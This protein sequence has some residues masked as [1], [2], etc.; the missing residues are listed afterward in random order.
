MVY[1]ESRQIRGQTY[2]YLVEKQRDGPRL[3]KTLNYYLGTPASL[4]ERL[5]SKEPLP[6]G[7]LRLRSFP[8]GRAALLLRVAQDLDLLTLVDRNARKRP[9]PG[10]SVGQ[11]LLLTLLARAYEPWSKA[12]TGRWFDRESFLRFLW[13]TPHRVHGGSILANL[14][15]LAEPGVQKRVERA[16]AQRLVAQGHRPSRLFWDVTNH[17]TY[18][19]E[20][21]TLPTPGHA[22]DLRYDLNLV[23]TGL[24][25]TE[26]HVPLFHETLPGNCDEHEVFAKAV[27]ALTVR[28]VG[29][30][31]DPGEMILVMDK[32]ANSEE[33]FAKATELMHVVGSVPSHLVPELMD[34]PVEEFTPL[35]ETGR[36][37]PLV[38]YLGRRELYGREWNVAVTYNAA[39]ARR[40]EA[41]YRRYEARFRER[42][43]KLQAGYL[44]T[45]G[46]A[47]TYS[48]A[49][50][51]AAAQVF[52]PYRSVFR[53]AISEEPRQFTWEVDEPARARLFRRF[54]KRVF[55]TDLDWDAAA[56]ART[57]EERYKVEQD[58]AWIKGEE[59]MPFAPLF[60]R[61]D[62]SIRA[63]AFLIVMGLMLWRLAFQ[64]I[65]QAGIGASEGEI[66]EALD[67]LKVALVAEGK[68]GKLRA[69]RWVLEEHGPL[70]ER[71]FRTMKLEEFVP[72]SRP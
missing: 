32:G 1:L 28:L 30:E 36:G 53:Y 6:S 45:K 2:W 22:K 34:H 26:D 63:H 19:E 71:L 20:G 56:M 41:T 8:F 9:Y 55:F 18:I 69:G 21:E 3:V 70:A 35:H 66:L 72:T 16:V 42:M 46:R 68:G 29:L 12:A 14:R 37:T 47:T 23:S 31:L 57:Y 4:L 52:P 48:G 17:S 43:A 59:M 33:N 7:H 62:A 60:V 64:R 5:R 54:G 15:R 25:V 51:E 10:L 40:K 13:K 65:R 49:A 67:E 61:K 27:E 24:V 38:G 50:A 39:T 44:R 58:F 11:Y